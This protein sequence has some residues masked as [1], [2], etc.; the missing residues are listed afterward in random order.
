MALV[1]Y[2]TV[3]EI[4]NNDSSDKH[5]GVTKVVV[6]LFS[7]V[8]SGPCPLLSVLNSILFKQ[9]IDANKLDP[10][11]RLA[12]GCAPRQGIIYD[13]CF[14]VGTVRSHRASPKQSVT[15]VG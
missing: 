3:V 11:L 12:L 7:L 14:G 9:T 6:R 15:G 10:V 5:W 1:I 8:S 4:Y 2:L 13:G